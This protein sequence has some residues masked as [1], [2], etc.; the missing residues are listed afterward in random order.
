MPSAR[1]A[2][3]AG[4]LVT[5]IAWLGLTLAHHGL[6]DP[7]APQRAIAAARH[8][9]L[10]EAGLRGVGH[11]IEAVATPVDAQ[12]ERVVFSQ[13]GRILAEAAVD[14]RAGVS[15]EL[16]Y[17]S[18]QVPYGSK[19][20]YQPWLL[21]LLGAVFVLC[22]AVV[23]LRRARNLDVLALL[24][25]LAPMIL[26]QLRYVDLSVISAV[27][28][29]LYLLVRCLRIALATS[30]EATSPPQ[31]ALF[32]VLT[33]RWEPARRIRTLRLMLGAL[34][35][36]FVMVCV[37]SSG[38]VDV[39]FALMEGA[40]RIVH[41]VLPYGHM[42][43]D[44][45]HGD[46]YPLLSYLLY[47]P[48]AA[49]SPVRDNW[50]SVDLGLGLTAVCAVA[51]A[52]MLAGRSALPRRR[53]AASPG[54]GGS[55]RSA[56]AWLS[57]P[58]LLAIA[59]TGTSDVVLAVMLLGAVI[60]WH[61]PRAAAGMLAAATWFK[62]APAVLIPPFLASLRGRRLSGALAVIAGVSV[63]ML[64]VLLALGGAAGV[65]DMIQ[66]VGWQFHRGSPQS[67]WAVLGLGALQPLGQATVLG[68]IAGASV[69]VRGDEAFSEQ[70]VRVAALVAAVIIA[71]QLSADYWAFLYL[72]WIVPPLG[73]CL[74]GSPAGRR[75]A[76][77]AANSMS[78]SAAGAVTTGPHRSLRAPAAP[79]PIGTSI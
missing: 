66:A 78:K 29:L 59:S 75:E 72:A 6:R 45:V 17:R 1:T 67:L 65:R 69:L 52:L 74:L 50:D 55:L 31:R 34:V 60:L 40:T 16:S 44:V 25:F 61:R 77:E 62:L 71:L 12:L 7:I 38:P 15:Q 10:I 2:A 30:P 36:V 56:V 5:L 79:V 35:L 57:F 70:P 47:A 68:L 21:G 49:V 3:L 39:V 53:L 13:G 46:T 37:S 42:P 14:R 26:L 19:L 23:P 4:L 48:L 54:D 9:P 18:L 8:D 58:P 20:A 22:T 64:A 41:G 73:I 63:G 76:G 33:V 51:V 32:D 43:S 27:P 11:P 24:S 28:G